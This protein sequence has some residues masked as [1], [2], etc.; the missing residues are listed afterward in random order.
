MRYCLFARKNLSSIAELQADVVVWSV[1]V[2]LAETAK[3][4]SFYVYLQ[5]L[6]SSKPYQ[7]LVIFVTFDFFQI[8][9][10]I[11]VIQTHEFVCIQVP[12]IQTNKRN[13]KINNMN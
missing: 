12:E 4:V 2:L 13:Y 7:T 8:T 6:S 9:S 3:V 5:V 1:S 11:F 10:C